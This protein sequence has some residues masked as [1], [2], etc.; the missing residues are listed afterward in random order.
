MFEI[1]FIWLEMLYSS[2]LEV[3]ACDRNQWNAQDNKDIQVSLTVEIT[4]VDTK[5]RMQGRCK[6]NSFV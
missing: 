4:D 2:K 6:L 5:G 3:R 1:S